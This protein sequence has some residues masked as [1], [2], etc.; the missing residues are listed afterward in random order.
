MRFVFAVVRSRQ[1]WLIAFVD[2]HVGGR[3]LI[4]MCHTWVL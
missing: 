3:S 2:V 4:K 1:A